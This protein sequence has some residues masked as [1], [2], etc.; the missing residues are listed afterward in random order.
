MKTKKPIKPGTL[1]VVYF[2]D[3][4]ASTHG[5]KGV[6]QIKAVGWVLHDKEDELVL[7]AWSV[8]DKETEADDVVISI[9]KHR[10]MKVKRM[11]E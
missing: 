4:T 1:V 11:K 5:G 9:V 7:T 2:M 10:V 3:H 6:A 8:I